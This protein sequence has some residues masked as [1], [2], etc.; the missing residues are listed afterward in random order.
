VRPGLP[1]QFLVRAVMVLA[2]L[3]LL[4]GVEVRGLV[5]YLAWT[6]IVLALLGEAAATFVFW[7]RSRAT[8]ARTGPGS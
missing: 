6:L 8:A 3:T 4:L 7:R 5:F 1:W 2:G